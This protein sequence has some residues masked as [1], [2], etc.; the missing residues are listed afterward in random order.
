MHQRSLLSIRRLCAAP[1]FIALLSAVLFAGGQESSCAMHGLGAAP[2]GAPAGAEMAKHAMTMAGSHEGGDNEHG[3]GPAQCDCTCIGT[4]TMSAPLA[5]PPAGATLLV[6]LVEP[7]PSRPIDADPA[8]SRP[9]APERLLPF[10]NGPP[11]ASV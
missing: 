6:A 1:L 10:A 8:L 3:R 7:A 4:C 11:S 9:R 2:A 5:N